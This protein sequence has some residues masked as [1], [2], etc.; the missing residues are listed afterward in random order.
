MGKNIQQR[1]A[2][3]Q[4]RVTHKLLPRAFFHTF[5]TRD[6]A[7]GYGDRLLA[8]LGRGVVPVELANAEAT[9]AASPTLVRVV[10]D[11][12]KLAPVTSSDDALLG[13]VLSDLGALRVADVTMK[14]VE[15]Y[16][17]QL[18][19]PKRHLTPGS[20]RKR[21]GALGR[22]LDWHLVRS[23]SKAANPFR[24]LPRGYSIY[25][26]TEAALAGGERVDMERDY[27]LPAEDEAKLLAALNGERKPGSQR[28][29]IPEPEVALMARLIL[30]TG[31]RLTEAMTLR[32]D[33]Q[34]DL[35]RRVIRRRHEGAPGQAQTPHRAHQTAPA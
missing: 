8:L 21:V 9:T 5:D 23:N 29:V 17:L 16:V 19:S 20:I 30:D 33:D 26:P 12:R 7:D 32:I 1:G 4:L 2:G 24:L 13:H 22:V 15:D 27:R 31:L 34:I 18:K 11:Y 3:Y 25:T 14:W 10:N 35:A 6:E 28:G